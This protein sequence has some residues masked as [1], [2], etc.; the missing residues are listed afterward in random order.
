MVFLNIITVTFKLVTGE[1]SCFPSVKHGIMCCGHDKR[2][3]P[4]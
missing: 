4:H 3:L 2:G 1:F